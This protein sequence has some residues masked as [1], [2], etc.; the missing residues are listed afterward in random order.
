[1]VYPFNW[2]LQFWES[3]L[4]YFMDALS[5]FPP[6][7]LCFFFFF[8]CCFNWN[9]Y[10]SII[11]PPGLNFSH[12][13]CNCFLLYFLR[14]FFHSTFQVLYCKFHFCYHSFNF[15]ELSKY[16]FPVAWTHIFS[17]LSPSPGT[18]CFLQVLFFVYVF[19]PV[20]YVYTFLRGLI[21]PS[22]LGVLRE[23]H[24]GGSLW[25]DVALPYLGAGQIPKEESSRL[26]PGGYGSSHLGARKGRPWSQCQRAAVLL[27]SLLLVLDVS[28]PLA[29][30]SV[31]VGEQ[32]T[33]SHCG[34]RT[35]VLPPFST[36]FLPSSRATCLPPRHPVVLWLCVFLFLFSF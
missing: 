4:I 25:G 13:L 14:I 9:S 30:A 27:S 11:G 31:C 7:S 1:M 33:L 29:L 15:Q 32:G 16:P 12:F 10:H 34:C 2:W 3:V 26:S 24:H 5:L 23:G 17:H 35:G 18:V 22:C 8:C 36:T 20:F 21:V 6:L 19:W 28:P